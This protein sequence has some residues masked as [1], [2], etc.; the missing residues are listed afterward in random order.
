MVYKFMIKGRTNTLNTPANLFKWGLA[1]SN[2]C[3]CCGKAGTLHHK[4]NNCKPCMST[5]TVRHNNIAKVIRE[6]IQKQYS[7][8]CYKE[9]SQISLQELM[10]N[11]EYQHELRDENKRLK[12]DIHFLDTVTDTINI[13]EITCPYN[14]MTQVNNEFVNTLVHRQETK[15]MKYRSLKEETEVL[16][17]MKTKLF[18]IVV[19]SLGHVTVKT[20]EN[21]Y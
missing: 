6:E 16:T 18:T 5:F 14:Q 15:E 11:N 7:Y 17:G 13:I 21:R 2:T 1:E 20:K 19:S 3:P 8:N 10:N 4:L 9:S 12:P